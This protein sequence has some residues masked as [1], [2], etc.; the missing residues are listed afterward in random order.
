MHNFEQSKLTPN[1]RLFVLENTKGARLLR[2][3]G[4]LG[5]GLGPNEDGRLAPIATTIRRDRSG[6]GAEPKSWP[7]RVTH[8][9]GEEVEGAV[10]PLTAADTI[11]KAVTHERE[12]K[13]EKKENHLTRHQ[14]KVRNETLLNSKCRI[15]FYYQSQR[16]RKEED[17]KRSKHAH[18]LFGDDNHE[19]LLNGTHPSQ[20]SLPRLQK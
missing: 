6:I 13:N 14:L 3:M 4:W 12:K 8:F 20:R 16:K 9:V 18:S 7:H 17:A 19:A 2:D 15:K 5:G 11:A 10:R 1:D